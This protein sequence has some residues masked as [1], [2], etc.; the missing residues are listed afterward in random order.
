V[1]QLPSCSRQPDWWKV[2]IWLG[3][4]FKHGELIPS[5]MIF[6]LESIFFASLNSKSSLG[7]TQNKELKDEFTFGKSH[8]VVFRVSTMLAVVFA[9]LLGQ[10]DSG[11]L[12]D[13]MGIML[14]QRNLTEMS[15]ISG[16]CQPTNGN[17]TGKHFG[18]SRQK[19]AFDM[20]Q[21]IDIWVNL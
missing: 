8:V 10:R 16:F 13:K 1:G 2:K 12:S 9:W 4:S 18:V 21:I 11:K 17:L 7:G 14:I 15:K 20:I 5:V 6:N 3:W 19:Y